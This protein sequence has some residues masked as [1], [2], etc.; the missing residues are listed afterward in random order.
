MLKESE[1]RVKACILLCP[2]NF[3]KGSI[4]HGEFL[5]RV[6]GNGDEGVSWVDINT[7]KSRLKWVPDRSY[8]KANHMILHRMVW[9]GMAWNKSDGW[10]TH[11]S[12][13]YRTLKLHGHRKYF[14]FCFRK[15]I[16][17]N[18][19]FSA[20]LLRGANYHI[21][22]AQPFSS[23][24]W[25]WATKTRKNRRER[26]WGKCKMKS[27]QASE[28]HEIWILWTLTTLEQKQKKS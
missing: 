10:S 25:E 17:N 8:S 5:F 28:N 19:S 13:S 18:D 14:P 12:D 7:Q 16:I 26:D 1:S 20:L 23:I 24:K 11:L 9:H 27:K 2:W 6:N 21:H 3:R 22:S 4:F 15:F